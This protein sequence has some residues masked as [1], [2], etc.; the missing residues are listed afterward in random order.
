M[1]VHDLL[2]FLRLVKRTR[3]NSAISYS[4]LVKVYRKHLRKEPV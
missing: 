4:D 2:V 1:G 3:S